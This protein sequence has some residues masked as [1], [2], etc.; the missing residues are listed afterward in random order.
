[1]VKISREYPLCKIYKALRN[2]SYIELHVLKKCAFTVYIH[3]KRILQQSQ[4]KPKF[5]FERNGRK[6]ISQNLLRK[7]GAYGSC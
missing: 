2:R 5:Q 3:L 4:K 6:S 7:A 1:M